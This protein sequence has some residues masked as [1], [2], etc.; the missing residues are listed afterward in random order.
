MEA[1]GGGD[2]SVAKPGAEGALTR[3][4]FSGNRADRGI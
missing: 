4:I 3:A 2:L 1:R